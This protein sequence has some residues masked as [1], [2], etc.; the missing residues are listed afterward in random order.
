MR[1]SKDIEGLKVEIDKIPLDP[2]NARRHSDKNIT[3]ISQSLDRFGQT[4]PVVLDRDGI[5]RAGN[6]T[7]TAARKLGWTHIAAVRLNLTGREAVEYGIAD[8][9][10]GEFSE[11]NMEELNMFLDNVGD[12][13]KEQLLF[14]DKDCSFDFPKIGWTPIKHAITDNI[15]KEICCCDNP[16]VFVF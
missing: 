2:Q 16:Q 4:K 11:W 13:V 15:D 6:G 1:F 10:T 7:V 8:N 3:M 5:C 14:K 9:R 12:E